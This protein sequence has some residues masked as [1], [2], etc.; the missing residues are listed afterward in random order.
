MLDRL[1]ARAAEKGSESNVGGMKPVGNNQQLAAVCQ[2]D[3]Y[4]AIGE[5]VSAVLSALSL[6]PTLLCKALILCPQALGC[7]LRLLRSLT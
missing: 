7:A 1:S 6:K 3:D 2:Y 5:H 4:E